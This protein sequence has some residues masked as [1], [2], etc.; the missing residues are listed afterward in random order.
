MSESMDTVTINGVEYVKKSAEA[1]LVH[2]DRRT[3]EHVCVIAT[4]GWIFEGWRDD[5]D[6]RDDDGPI[7][8]ARAHV[9]RYWDNGM[10]ISGLSD[11]AHKDEYELDDM[12]KVC[13][14][15]KS[16]V[17]FFPLMW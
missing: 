7:V 1:A 5:Y 10:G 8:L 15:A 16:V 14:Y 13:V 12:G 4:N 17:A 2:V 3:W 9:V 11:P 6:D